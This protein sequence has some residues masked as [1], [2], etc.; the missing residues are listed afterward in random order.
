MLSGIRNTFLCDDNIWLNLEDVLAHSHDFSLFHSKSLFEIIILGELHVGH[1]LSLFIFKW[2]IQKDN[3][4]VLDFSS[5]TWM[6]H[7]FVE[8]NTIKD[9]AVFDNTTWN[10]LNL[11]ISFDIDFDVTLGILLVDGSDGLDCE[12]D[13]KISPLGGEFGSDGALDDLDQVIV[14]L[15]VDSDL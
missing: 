11:G 14:I 15:K 4:W 6:G 3:S 8:N 9:L 7:I 5:H 13:K 2:A 12:V 10:L 1:G